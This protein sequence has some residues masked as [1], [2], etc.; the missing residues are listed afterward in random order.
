[1]PPSTRAAPRSFLAQTVQPLFA[2]AGSQKQHAGIADT[3]FPAASSDSAQA[4][5]GSRLANSQSSASPRTAFSHSARRIL[6]SP[7]CS[8][9]FTIVLQITRLTFAGSLIALYSS[10]LQSINSA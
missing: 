6:S 1:M 4:A 8:L 10:D 2:H 5:P 3:A 7:A 9:F